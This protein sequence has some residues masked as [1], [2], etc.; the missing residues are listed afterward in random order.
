MTNLE[1]IRKEVAIRSGTFVGESDPILM[2]ATMHDLLLEQSVSTLNE[3]HEA[4]LKA[5]I[6]SQQKSH[7]ETKRLAGKVVTEGTEYACDQISTAIKATVEE[8]REE[9]K[10]EVRA[11]WVV[12]Q[13]ARRTA[14]IGAAVSAACAVIT[15]GTV[16]TNVL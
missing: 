2:I 4:N 11:A 12:I 16:L 8:S 6:N 13:A 3:Q 15:L 14:V 7:E 10:Q 5:L 9:F 1:E